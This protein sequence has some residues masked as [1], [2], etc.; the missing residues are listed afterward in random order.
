M[1]RSFESDQRR[2]QALSLP[3]GLPVAPTAS[4]SGYA[5]DKLMVPNVLGA[6]V[7]IS[8]SCSRRPNQS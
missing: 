3:V 6:L 2:I 1:L 4:V 8:A 5:V 7:M